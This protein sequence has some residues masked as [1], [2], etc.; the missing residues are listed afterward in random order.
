MCYNETW[1]KR[2]IKALLSGSQ[3][4]NIVCAHTINEINKITTTPQKQRALPRPTSWWFARDASL[5]LTSWTH[6]TRCW[7]PPSYSS[8]I[9]ISGTRVIDSPLVP[10]WGRSLVMTGR[11]GARSVSVCGVYNK[12][13]SYYV[14]NL[15]VMKFCFWAAIL[16]VC[17]KNNNN[18][19]NSAFAFLNLFYYHSTTSNTVHLNWWKIILHGQS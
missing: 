4:N 6:R 16:V 1:L 8:S 12:D 11:H 5:R 9:N 14:R 18:N 19:N 10:A 7:R 15:W 3:V 13:P 17:P 2:T